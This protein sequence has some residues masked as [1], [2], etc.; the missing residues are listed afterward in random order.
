MGIFDGVHLGHQQ[1]LQQLRSNAQEVGGEVVIITFW[2]PPK[3]A[4]AQTRSAPV[5]LLT[6]FDEKVAMLAQLGVDHLL[7]IRFTK[8][9]SQLSAQDFI[10]QVLIA[11]VGITQLVVGH[12]HHFGKDRTGDVALLQETGRYHGFSVTEVLPVM[13]GNV[14]VSSTKIRQLLL[15]GV[16]EEVPAYLGRLYE[17]NC[18]VLQQGLGSGQNLNINL[19]ATSTHKLIPPDGRYSVHV[20]HQNIVAEGTLRIV[21]NDDTP[22]MTLIVASAL[23]FTL[24]IANLCIRFSKH[25]CLT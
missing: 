18:S 11:R 2:P 9:F 6:T 1:L 19:A 14:M 21:R 13:A 7:K 17:I 16:V 3:L 23:N 12:D 25:L 8:T 10:Q 20:A 24:P 22:T 4:L 5:Q 15:A